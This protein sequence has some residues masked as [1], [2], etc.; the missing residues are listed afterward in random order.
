MKQVIHFEVYNKIQSLNLVPKSVPILHTT[1]TILFQSCDIKNVSDDTSVMAGMEKG[2][3]SA[4]YYAAGNLNM[5][6]CGN[7][8]GVQGIS[9]HVHNYC[10]LRCEGKFSNKTVLGLFLDKE[11]YG[12]ISVSN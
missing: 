8:T 3:I 5:T 10:V 7:Q 1:K 4:T 12:F 9:I 2:S 6:N 11:V